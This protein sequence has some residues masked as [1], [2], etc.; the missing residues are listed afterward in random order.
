V[1]INVLIVFQLVLIVQ[2]VQ[3]ILLEVQYLNVHA[4]TAIM[5]KMCQFVQSVHLNVLLAQV[6]LYV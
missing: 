5:T 6:K 2:V 3:Q 1:I 4:Q